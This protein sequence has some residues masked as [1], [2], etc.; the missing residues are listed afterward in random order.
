MSTSGK[1]KRVKPT[2]KGLSYTL[3]FNKRTF[4]KALNSLNKALENVKLEFSSLSV[5]NTQLEHLQKVITDNVDEAERAFK[6]LRSVSSEDA[7]L[8]FIHDKEKM[9]G[10]QE[11]L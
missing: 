11:G 1:E 6:A 9:A 8:R 4:R 2:E 10:S 7:S 3:E 5:D